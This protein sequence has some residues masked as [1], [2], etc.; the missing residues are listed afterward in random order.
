[1]SMTLDEALLAHDSALRRIRELEEALRINLVG[2]PATKAD[3]EA[4]VVALEAGIVFPTL[5]AANLVNVAAD[6]DAITGVV[7]FRWLLTRPNTA[8]AVGDVIRGNIPGPF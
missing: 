1:M 8:P 3:I 7:E 6:A 2:Q 4:V 5:V